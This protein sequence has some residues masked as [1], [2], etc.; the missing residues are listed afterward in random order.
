MWWKV[1][2]SPIS[3]IISKTMDKVWPDKMSEMERKSIETHLRVEVI[4]ALKENDKAI[5]NVLD[6]VYA[7]RDSAR[8]LAIQE[9]INVKAPKWAE[10]IRILP[11]PGFAFA[12]LIMYVASAFGYIQLSE[13]HE[14]TGLTI[15]AFYFG[16]RS[17]Q[18]VTEKVMDGLN[19]KK[20]IENGR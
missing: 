4:R 15:I 1:L 13:F 2:V 6:K 3:T 8:Q 5:S 19:R 9:S 12:A 20:Y 10:V 17:V 16:A 18:M 14:T 11:R 7:D